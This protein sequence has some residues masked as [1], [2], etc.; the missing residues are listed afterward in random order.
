MLNLVWLAYVFLFG[1]ILLRS[2]CRVDPVLGV[3]LVVE[4]LGKILQVQSSL[5]SCIMRWHAVKINQ[6]SS[7]VG[8]LVMVDNLALTHNVKQSGDLFVLELHVPFF[9]NIFFQME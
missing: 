4:K 2:E 9:L 5:V 1:G 8:N 3:K 7:K 6:I